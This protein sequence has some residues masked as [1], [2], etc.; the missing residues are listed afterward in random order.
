[1][2]ILEFIR[3][4]IDHVRGRP[5]RALPTIYHYLEILSDEFAQQGISIAN[6]GKHVV[7][8]R[9]HTNGTTALVVVRYTTDQDL[10]HLQ[11]EHKAGC[12]IGYLIDD[13]IWFMAQDTALSEE[14]RNRIAHFLNNHVA[15]LMPLVDV[16][17]APSL[18]ILKRSP[19]KTCVKLDPA[20][21][22]PEDAMSHHDGGDQI[23][24]VF[25]GT[26]TH[27]TD[28]QGVASGIRAALDANPN[29]HLTTLL[30]ATGRELIPPG[31]Q[32]RHL[33]DMFF[34]RFQTWLFHQK[35]HI[36][37][38]PYAPNPV[39]DGRS[40]LKFHQHALVGAAGIYSP[41][42]P[43]VDAVQ[44]QASGLLVEYDAFAF[45][46]AIEDLARNHSL[47]RALATAQA[48]RSRD[49]GDRARLAALLAEALGLSGNAG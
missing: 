46:S 5:K 41:T 33:G 4:S 36:A 38:A 8:L 11:Q 6:F 48:I 42:R 44:H 26:S 39:N 7:R 25:L 34:P 37:L 13:D 15:R 17:F 28:F 12:R 22:G 14:Y 27:R 35:F 18:Q 1:L 20:H 31:P 3:S 2:H 45:Q 19:H 30:G 24:M 21:L 32:V 49:L 29:L 9:N 23:N 47:R 40:N 16:V 10:A 43:F